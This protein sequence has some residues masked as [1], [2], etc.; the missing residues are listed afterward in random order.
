[1]RNCVA[2]C[3]LL[4][5]QVKSINSSCTCANSSTCWDTPGDEDVC[6]VVN[7][8]VTTPQTLY[9]RGMELF[10][11]A[12]RRWEQALTFSGRPGEEEPDCSS[13]TLGVGESTAEES[14]EDLTSAEFVHKLERLLQRAYRLQ[15]EFEGALGMS[16][17]SSHSGSH[18]KTPVF[19][20][21]DL[22]DV[23]CLKDS[24]SIASND[25][26]MSAA[27]VRQTPGITLPGSSSQSLFFSPLFLYIICLL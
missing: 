17:P 6:N 27:E 2:E 7:I 22:D 16:A 12:L 5:R 8:P 13:F 23:S 26:F 25:S 3:G 14:I 24:I 1:M 18:D 19:C 20:R 4:F 21:D 10:E 15:E 9:L 11:E